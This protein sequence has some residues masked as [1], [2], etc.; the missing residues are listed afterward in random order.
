MSSTHIGSSTTDTTGENST[1]LTE[2]TTWKM[3][4]VINDRLPRQ[5]KDEIYSV[6]GFFQEDEGYEPPQGSFIGKDDTEMLLEV[7]KSR[8]ML[9]EDPEDRKDSLWIWG[10]FKEPLYPFLLL[11]IS[12]SEKDADGN[13]K[14]WPPL[15]AQISHR[16]KDGSVF[17]EPAD[18]KVRNLEQLNADPFG[19]AKVEIYEEDVVGRISFQAIS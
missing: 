16:R 2:A 12:L 8:W 5:S 15:Y 14:P 6:S 10:L 9:S 19:A 3:R 17:L 4:L 13:M 11:Q 1:T 7:S 18:L